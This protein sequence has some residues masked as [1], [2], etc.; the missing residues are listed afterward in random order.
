MIQDISPKKFNNQFDPEAVAN[1]EDFVI[2][3]KENQILVGICDGVM[4]F[5][6]VADIGVIDDSMRYLF[7]IDTERYFLLG[8]EYGEKCAEGFGFYTMNELREMKLEPW[9]N[10]FVIYTAKHLSDWYR[11]NRFCG[12]CG[13]VMKH[14]EKERAMKCPE[15]GYT[16]YPR[17]MP[18]VIVG[19][20][21]GDSIL[22]TRYRRGYGHNALIAGFT[23]I[24]ET[25]EETVARE[26]M[27]E[28]GLN[29]KNIRYYKSQPWGSAN[30]I[31]LGFYCD[32]DGSTEIHMDDQELKYA[33]WVKR[34]D[35]V[36]QPDEY[37][38]TNEMMKMFKEGNI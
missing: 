26:V 15:C 37:S 25:V 24:G 23:E 30:D 31:L 33:Q 11:D 16:A 34:E 3:I 27:E 38:L 32:V 2:C 6:R 28:S 1:D 7:S 17:I 13:S 10:N 21:N 5:P 29:V 12:R 14:S 35:I 20:T 9:H 36:L 4:S 19:V 22:L 8:G 18:A